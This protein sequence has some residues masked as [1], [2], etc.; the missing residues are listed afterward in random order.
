MTYFY[1]NIGYFKVFKTKQVPNQSLL[2]LKRVIQ[3]QNLGLKLSKLKFRQ[4]LIFR[5]KEKT[6]ELK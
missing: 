2:I 3:T 5:H 6:R 4:F 1:L